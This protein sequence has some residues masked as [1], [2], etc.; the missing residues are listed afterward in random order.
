[1][2]PRPRSGC[3]SY[4]SSQ[5]P[6]SR[7]YRASRSGSGPGQPS[8]TARPRSGSPASARAVTSASRAPRCSGC[9]ATSASSSASRA[10]RSGSAA[11]GWAGDPLQQRHAGVDVGGVGADPSLRARSGPIRRAG[12][13]AGPASARGAPRGGPRRAPGHSASQ[14]TCWASSVRSSTR[15]ISSSSLQGSGSAGSAAIARR[16]L[17]SACPACPSARQARA[18]ARWV[19]PARV[20][21]GVERP[22][23]PHRR[24]PVAGPLR[25]LGLGPQPRRAIRGSAARSPPARRGPTD[26]AR[27]HF[28]RRPPGRRRAAQPGPARAAPWLV[29]AIALR[30]VGACSRWIRVR[31]SRVLGAAER[32]DPPRTGLRSNLRAHSAP[33]ALRTQPRPA[34]ASAVQQ[35]VGRHPNLITG[36]IGPRRWPMVPQAIGDHRR[37]GS[38]GATSRSNRL[39]RVAARRRPGGPDITPCTPGG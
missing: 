27:T 39:D 35:S 7:Q 11:R 26:P 25:P 3:R 16:R 34:S 32:L 4:S 5:R 31:W 18:S 8:S 12:P 2:R 19:A 28:H 38:I 14:T 29:T 6:R 10:G 21:G 37:P 33:T 15:R 22:P 24:G 17:S 36:C 30:V 23:G 9:S 13:P 20:V 1:M